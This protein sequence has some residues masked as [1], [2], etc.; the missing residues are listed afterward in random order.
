MKSPYGFELG[1]VRLRI[2]PTQ[3]EIVGMGLAVLI[4]QEV[5]P[6]NR[7]AANDGAEK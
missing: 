7:S 1:I 6:K 3:N 2:G 5:V 4:L